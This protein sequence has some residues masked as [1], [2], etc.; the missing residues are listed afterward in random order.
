MAASAI[1]A[2]SY[3]Q[4]LGFV[5]VFVLFSSFGLASRLH[6]AL[7]GEEAE[8]PSSL[9]VLQACLPPLTLPQPH[10]W[11]QPP[12][13]YSSSLLYPYRHTP[14]CDTPYCCRRGPCRCRASPTRPC[15]RG[16]CAPTGSSAPPPQASS[17]ARAPAAA[18]AA[19]CRPSARLG[20]HAR[21]SKHSRRALRRQCRRRRRQGWQGRRLL[22]QGLR[23][24]P[25]RRRR[26]AVRASAPTLGPPRSCLLPRGM[27]AKLRRPAR[28]S[29]RRGCPRGAT[30]TS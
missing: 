14:Y 19:G 13:C 20:L 5:A 11:L 3:R 27:W 25:R 7:S 17:R 9:L 24:Q 30:P 16:G 21:T 2:S 29:W 26:R 12:L 15:S 22:R 10:T 18:H 23:R 8:T 6:A 4:L 1:A 28:P